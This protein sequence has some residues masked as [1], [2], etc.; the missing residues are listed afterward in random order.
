MDE[1][2]L[3]FVW[4]QASICALVHEAAP[5]AFALFNFM[6]RELLGTVRDIGFAAGVQHG[7][8]VLPGTARGGAT[9]R[10]ALAVS[11][12]SNRIMS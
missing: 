5:L 3:T 12:F 10:S 4:N 2:D 1:L 9:L 8:L 11:N 7:R 6:L